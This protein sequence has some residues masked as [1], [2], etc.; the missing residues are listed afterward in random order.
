MVYSLETPFQHTKNSVQVRRIW[1]SSLPLPTFVPKLRHGGRQW[2]ERHWSGWLNSPSCGTLGGKHDEKSVDL[3]GFH[4]CPVLGL[5]RLQSCPFLFEIAPM[6]TTVSQ[7]SGQSFH[8]YITLYTNF[9]ALFLP[10]VG[11]LRDI[12]YIFFLTG[13]IYGITQDE[14]PPAP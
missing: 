12:S 7:N 14:E 13:C 5:Q 4:D 6:F 1:F 11:F 3:R 2:M 9:I 10:V 8:G